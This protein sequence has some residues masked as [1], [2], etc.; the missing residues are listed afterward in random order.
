[1]TVMNN[2][3]AIRKGNRITQSDL[4]LACGWSQGRLSHYENGSRYPSIEDAKN[5][6]RGLSSLGAPCSLD[7]LFP[8]GDD[9]EA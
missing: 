3:R 9:V 6:V 2:L 1:M 8:I 4:A 5:I 7:Q